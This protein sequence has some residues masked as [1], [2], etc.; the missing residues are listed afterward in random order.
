MINHQIVIYLNVNRNVHVEQ[1]RV[2]NQQLIQM[3]KS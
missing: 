3:W 2:N 1:S